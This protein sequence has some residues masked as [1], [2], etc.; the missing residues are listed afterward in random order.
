[1]AHWLYPANVKFYDVLGAFAQPSTYWPI[2][3]KV[4]VGDQVYV[5]LAAPHKQVGFACE[6]MAVDI[7]LDEI[8]EQV[9]IPQKASSVFEVDQNPSRNYRLY[10]LRDSAFQATGAFW[11]SRL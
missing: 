6:V 2:N 1:M 9:R 4:E 10:S 3:S 5:Y 8:I 11:L 7:E